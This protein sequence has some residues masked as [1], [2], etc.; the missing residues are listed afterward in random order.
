MSAPSAEDVLRARAAALGECLRAVADDGAPEAFTDDDAL[1][2]TGIGASEAPA[3]AMTALARARGSKAELVPLSAFA[4]GEPRARGESLAVF[5]QSLSPNACLALARAHEFTRAVLFTSARG[6]GESLASFRGRVVTLPEKSGPAADAIAR[7]SGTLVR[8][9]GPCV[10]TLG[11]AIHVGATRAG[12]VAALLDAVDAAPSRA[13]AAVAAL[14]DARMEGRVAFVTAGG[15]GELCSGV[16]ALW[17]EALY[18]TRPPLFDVLEIAHG[19]FQAFYEA[20]I[21]LIALER[22]GAE[23]DLFDRL[24]QTLVPGRHVLVRLSSDLPPPLAA[25]DHFA[26][27]LELVCRALRARP[28]DLRAWPGSGSDAPLYDLGRT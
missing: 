4:I 3:R 23:R 25:L 11:A 9:L 14:D 16:C 27:V 8:V 13:R 26:Q 1:V 12:D 2:V 15:Y 5:S 6:V 21:L 22:P 18:A 7:E 17:S 20:P 19:P 28:R 10:A 24:A